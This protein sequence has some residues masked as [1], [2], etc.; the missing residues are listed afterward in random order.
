[1]VRCAVV[2]VSLLAVLAGAA[3][4]SAQYFGRNKVRYDRLDFRILQ[5]EH[6]DIYYYA[7]E[8]EAT[9]HAARMAERWYARF[10][11][12]LGHTFTRRQPLV[13]YASH[14]HFTQTNVTP[15][16]P[17]EGIGGLTERNKSRI[18]MPF[19][20]GLGETDHVL[21]HEIAHAFQI[22]VAR[23]AKQD[24]FTLPGWF[25]EGM[26]EYLSLGAGNPHTMMW[27]RDA[28]LYTRLPTVKQL[29]DPRYFPYRY[30]HAFWSYLA[31][32]YGDEII[33]RILRSKVRGMV[34]RLERATGLTEAELTRDWHA[35]IE[36]EIGDVE[37]QPRA[38]PAAQPPAG[39]LQVAP[40]LSPGGTQLMFVSERDSLS[41][42]L[43]LAD[44][45]SGAVIRKIVSTAADPHFDSLQYIHSAGAWDG[46]GRQFA[47]AALS[48]GNPVLVIL[49]VTDPERRTEIPLEDLG[50]AYNPSWSPDGTR[51]VFSALKGGLSDLYIYSVE[52]GTVQ[53]LTADAFADLQP[54]WSPDGRT[55]ALVTDRFTTTLDDLR[56]GALRIGLL[57]LDS[58]AIRQM[59]PDASRAKQVSPQWSPDG[60]AVY[61]VSDRDG[62]SN[63]Y[64][65]DLAT[66][67]LRQVTDVAGGIS[68]ITATSPALAVASR[69]GTLAFSVYRNGRYE[70][71]TLPASVAQAAPLVD[72]PAGAPA[73][74]PA[75]R[76]AGE[77]AGLL[78][79]PNTGLPDTDGF[80]VTPYDDRLRLEAVAPPYI[81]AVTSGGFGGII[82]GSIGVAFADVLRDRQL[83]TILRAG[84]DRDDLA[85]QVAYMNRKGQWNWGVAGGFVPSRFLGARRAIEREAELVTRETAHLRYTHMWGGLTAHYH[86][87]RAQRFEFGAGVRRT[88]FQWQT[89]T[90]VVDA[91]QG[92]TISRSLAET[93]AGRPVSVGEGD[94]AF[95][96]DTS[97]SGPTSPILGRRL[98]VGV[99]PAF[100]SLYFADVGIDARQYFMPVRP[101]TVAVRVEHVGR[102]GPDAGDARLTPLVM[103]LQTLVR[104]YDL[105]VFTVD[106]C[107]RSALACSPL[108]ELAGG[109]LALLNVEL[110][111]PLL[112]LLSG[113][114][115][116]GR[117][118]IEALA[119]VDSGFLWTSRRGGGWEEDRFR[120]VGAGARANVGGF[121][122]ELTAARPFDRADKDW[123]YS[124][125][126][127]PGF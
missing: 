124:L 86:L 49:D 126:L 117:V 21:G 114:L 39:R 71:E 32:R 121:V 12:L 31:S 89:I 28:A 59:S 36:D 17:G 78:N 26:A 58:G 68:G 109:R 105:R 76:P 29:S 95:V 11:Q 37:A 44:A 91:I 122:F 70:I 84:T 72:A 106:E 73:E 75:D 14:P 98:R 5:T 93:D 53:Q 101:L 45:A 102:Y 35:A 90:R 6:F 83:Q 111:A 62:V 43:F 51:I 80:T 8:E 120:S 57:D 42:D 69:A 88:G 125:L 82:R 46:S 85:A 64:R 97:V 1:M 67:Q 25:I 2:V 103:G 40:A 30:G 110:R 60:D 41:L 20:A 9:R 79:D 3:P 56:F 116:Y 104:G 96:H 7:E 119:F 33:G 16:T 50:E 61:F 34:P 100:G 15:S 65:A 74:T 123:T 108:D 18:A 81:G 54:V 92:T 112:G 24:A 52:T 22:D 87:N 115:R 55:I 66:T 48:G 13:L 99:E 27:L 63:V 113:D 77:L 38:R 19:A 107:G 94:A 23:R 4:A 10:S 118:P 127:R 47:M